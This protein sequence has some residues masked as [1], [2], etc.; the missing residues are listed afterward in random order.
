MNYF[1]S[2]FLKWDG[3]YTYRLARGNDIRDCRVLYDISRRG[4]AQWFKE[5][6]RRPVY[7]NIRANFFI[8]EG[9]PTV[10]LINRAFQFFV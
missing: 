5:N 10:L 8:E 3:T 7:K 2:I 6:K 4:A 9:E 1:L